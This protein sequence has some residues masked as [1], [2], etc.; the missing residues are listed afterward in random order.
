MTPDGL[1][2][3]TVTKFGN[4]WSTGS[5]QCTPSTCP[6]EIQAKAIAACSELQ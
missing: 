3:D 6:A 2:V 4:S 1:V 5:Q